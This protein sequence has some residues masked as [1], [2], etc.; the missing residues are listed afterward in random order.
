TIFSRFWT[1]AR[2]SSPWTCS[3][4]RRTFFKMA[5]SALTHEFTTA[6][7]GT[8]CNARDLPISWAVRYASLDGSTWLPRLWRIDCTLAATYSD[9]SPR[10]MEPPSY[11]GDYR[12]LRMISSDTLSMTDSRFVITCADDITV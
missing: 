3:A 8:P 12:T 10:F 9:S 7:T 5:L 11:P 2:K 6:S 4:S 1:I